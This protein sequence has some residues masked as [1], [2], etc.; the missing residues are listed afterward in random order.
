MESALERPEQSRAMV[1]MVVTGLSGKVTL[2]LG[3]VALVMV[4]WL[5]AVA[6]EPGADV[7][8]TAG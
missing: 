7:G 3:G 4:V 1:C 6:V 8:S 5:E 2:R